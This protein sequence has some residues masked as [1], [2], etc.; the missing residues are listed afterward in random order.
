MPKV[1]CLRRTCRCN[2]VPTTSLKPG[3]QS[4]SVR[5][6]LSDCPQQDVYTLRYTHV[7]GPRIQFDWDDENRKHLSVH[8]VTPDE[9]EDVLNNNPLD[10]VRAVTAF[11]ASVMDTK[12]FLEMSQ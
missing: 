1:G 3:Q 6:N 10:L 9:F 11:S 4:T 12:A 8:K 7:G 2:L 5:P